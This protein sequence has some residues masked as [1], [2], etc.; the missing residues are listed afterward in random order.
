MT[1]PEQRIERTIQALCDE[2]TWGLRFFYANKALHESE[3]R[4]TP[5]LFDTFYWSCLDQAGLILSRIV[6][7]KV[8]DDDSVNVSYL[9]GYA[10]NNPELFHF[11]KPGEVEKLVKTHLALLESYKSDIGILEDQRDRNL[12]HL[13]RKHVNQPDWREN[14][15]QLDLDRVEQLYRDLISMMATYHRLFYGGEIDFGDW[16]TISKEEVETL[17]NFF[18]AYQSKA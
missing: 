13:D 11:A 14:Q 4:I 17:I 1:T 10:R 2:L 12:A 16:Q 18:E 15:T 5:T 7:A 8:K 6:I 3:L 9:L